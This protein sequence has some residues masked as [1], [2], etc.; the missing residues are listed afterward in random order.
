[1][2]TT[3]SHSRET[4]NPSEAQSFRQAVLYRPTEMRIEQAPM[5]AL[6]PGDVLLRVD[7]ALL[8]GTDVRIYEGRKQK[9]VTFPTVLGHE[10]A[11]TV[12]DA[13]GALPEGV[14]MGDQVAVY[15]L[16]TCGQCTACRRGHENICRNRK[17]F[18]YQLTGG[19]SQYVHVPAAARQNLVPVPGVPAAQAAIIEP[20]ACAYNGQQLAGMPRAQTALIVGCGPLGL[21]HIGLAKSLGVDKVAA[22][23]PIAGRREMAS[24]F[25]AD[26]VLAPGPDTAAVLDDFTAGGIDVLVMAIGRIDAL[27][28]YLGS[29]APGARVSVFAG[30]GA[31][32]DLAVSANDV[33][34]NEWTIVGASSCRLDGFHA[35]APM[36]ASGQLPV[37]ELIGTQLPLDRAVEA[38]QLAGSGADMRVGV[39]PWA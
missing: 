36:V 8:C 19:L 34:Y 13:N 12:V 26:L 33:H 17:A 24:R 1:M 15:P 23:D 7:A 30:F 35:V 27:T 4:V 11:G 10:F 18:G 32:A 31:D 39:D 6:Q 29:L 16:V 14:Q 3:T 21:I 20:V 2:T 38:I 5:P 37:A 25:G 9:N 22:V 28:P